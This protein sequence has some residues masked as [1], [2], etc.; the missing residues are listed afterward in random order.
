MSHN[1]F[2]FS[3]NSPL[4]KESFSKYDG[5][6]LCEKAVNRIFEEI[7]RKS[8]VDGEIISATKVRAILNSKDSIKEKVKILKK[9]I[10]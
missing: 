3:F 6:A 1:I 5:H 9:L 10:T 7:P 2:N 8:N 4:I